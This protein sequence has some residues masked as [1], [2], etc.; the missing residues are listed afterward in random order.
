M[1]KEFNDTGLCLPDRHYMLDYTSK[2]R[3]ILELIEK[4]KYFT[5]NRPRQFGK[6]TLLNILKENLNETNHYLALSISLEGIDAH[7]QASD[8]A[9]AQM[10]LR[11][12][13]E[14]LAHTAPTLNDY[15]IQQQTTENDLE[16]L[17]T[18]ITK[19]VQ[20]SS[21]KLVL[22]IDEVDQSSNYESFLRFLAMLR[23]K[24]LQRHLPYSV[25][26]HSIVLAGVHDIKTLKYKIHPTSTDTKYNSPW[27]IAADFEIV[28]SFTA[29]EIAP[30]LADYGKVEKVNI[31]T[32]TI[33]QQIY[34]YTE[35]HPFLVSKICKIIAEKLRPIPINNELTWQATHIDQ[36]VHLL[37]KQKNT[38]FDS[39]IKN[40]ETNADLYKLVYRILLEGEEIAYNEDN[41][42][43]HYGVLYGIFKEEKALL[44]IANRIYEQRIYNYMA[45]KTT[46]A[47]QST[48]FNLRN[49]F[50]LPDNALDIE[51]I[52]LKFQQFLKEEHSPK[53]THFLER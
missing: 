40:L 48:T 21:K 24:Y 13:I 36:A 4:G 46:A 50:I 22:L 32:I 18:L 7:W 11:K 14:T 17:S 44:K 43:I 3:A 45:S 23:K 15:L 41:P 19:L 53:G 51:K 25:T 39:L 10:F 6:T 33:S 38:N 8:T 30:M 16:S 34:Y 2:V 20:H 1:K 29:K 9:F 5:I 52:L 35:G 31:D 26:F 49:Q 47:L 12:L 28:M 37:L 42:I 27:N